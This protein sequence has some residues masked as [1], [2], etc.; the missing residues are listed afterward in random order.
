MM[1]AIH[2]KKRKMDKWF[3]FNANHARTIPLL[4]HAEPNKLVSQNNSRQKNPGDMRIH[5]GKKSSLPSHIERTTIQST[6]FLHSSVRSNKKASSII[7]SSWLIIRQKQN[8]VKSW[9]TGISAAMMMTE[10]MNAVGICA[11]IIY[12]NLSPSVYSTDH[13]GRSYTFSIC[14][15][16]LE[17]SQ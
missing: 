2:Y 1:M 9:N 7:C 10:I 6:K 3:G 11:G 17:Y 16:I 15:N 4:L 12:N 5:V 14:K 8:L 13:G